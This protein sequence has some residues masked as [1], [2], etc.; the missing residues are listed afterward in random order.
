VGTWIGDKWGMILIKE[1][2]CPFCLQ[3][4]SLRAKTCNKCRGKSKLVKSAKES[5]Q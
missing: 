4:K 1:E 5:K 2:F 3:P